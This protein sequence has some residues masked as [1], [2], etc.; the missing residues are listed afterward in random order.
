M[1]EDSQKV[2]GIHLDLKYQMPRKSYLTEWA[3]RLPAL[4]IN[5]VLL[6]YEDKFPFQQ[7]PF[8]RDP[9][10]F[11][12]AELTAFLQLMR[13]QGLRIVPLVQTLSHLE[14]A[15]AHDELAHLREGPGIPTQICP[16]NPE[17][18]VFV[19][20]LVDEVL[21]Y[22]EDDDWFHLGADEAWALG[23]CDTCAP[24]IEDGGKINLWLPHTLA[25]CER[26]RQRGKRPVVWDDSFWHEPEL[27][28]VMPTDVILATWHYHVTK[29]SPTGT[30]V[31]CVE[32]Y[33]AQGRDVLTCPCC[34]W[35]VLFPQRMCL[36]NTAALIELAQ[37]RNLAGV[38]NTVWTCFHLPLPAF[39][40][41]VAATGA[42]A[43]GE[44]DRISP[45][46][47]DAFFA[48]EFGVAIDG[49][50]AAMADLG[51]LWEVQI[52]GL[53]RPVTPLLHGCM[54]M[55][56]H[57]PGGQDERKER[58][59]YPLDWEEI[60]FDALYA[61]KLEL[62][63]AEPNFPDTCAR[64]ASFRESYAVSR[65]TLRQLAETA[66]AHQTEA[67]LLAALADLKTAA[68]E[69]L[70][71]LLLDDGDQAAVT[72]EWERCGAALRETLTP[73]LEPRSVDRLLTMWWQ[74]PQAALL[75]RAHVGP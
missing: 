28:S 7:Y 60:D 37:S 22:H 5:T 51:T 26:V 4:G 45:E 32:T 65:A 49:V 18:V 15:L 47:E 9:D 50:S 40:H 24:K 33:T 52:K 23:T 2:V 14:F 75:A 67:A 54:D 55:V 71:L 12:P 59:A 3:Q 19:E 27:S 11:T 56:L 16:S 30:P 35:G 17:A 70:T 72:S 68:A 39:T 66:T 46:W 48:A 42:L 69:V 58:G 1:Q 29:L 73:F 64:L 25:M 53:D 44:C 62:L 8:L 31:R 38:I 13:D 57:Y 43:A 61:R 21:A 74:P 34:N 36:D 10:A 41:G 63:A 6:E 20:S